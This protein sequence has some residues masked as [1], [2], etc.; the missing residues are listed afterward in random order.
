MQEYISL[1]SFPCE[2]TQRALFLRPE[3]KEIAHQ[4]LQVKFGGLCLEYVVL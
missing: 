4:P 2:W 1:Y 3:S